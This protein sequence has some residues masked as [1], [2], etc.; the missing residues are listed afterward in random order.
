MSYLLPGY[1]LGFF[2]RIGRFPGE[3]GNCP[4]VNQLRE[5]MCLAGESNHNNDKKIEL[6][7]SNCCAVD[8][9]IHDMSFL[10]KNVPLGVRS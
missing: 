4:P 10:G 8:A 7:L 6:F 2:F 5:D 9:T 1:R 3:Y